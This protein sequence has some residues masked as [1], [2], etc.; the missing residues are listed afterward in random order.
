MFTKRAFRFLLTG[1]IA[2]TVGTAVAVTGVAGATASTHTLPRLNPPGMH[3]Q[4]VAA[5]P[6]P[7]STSSCGYHATIPADRFKGIP[8]FDA[9][10]A[11]QP[12]LVRFFTT[13]GVITVKM[14]TDKAPCT[15]YSFRFLASRGYFNQTHCHRLTVQFIYVLQCGDPTGTGSGAPGYSFNDENLAGATYPAGTVAMANAGPNTNGSQFFFTWKDTTLSPAYT[16]FGT[17]VGGMDVLQKIAAAGDDQ[18]NGP[19]DG[20]P[21]LYTAFLFVQ[22][23]PQ[24]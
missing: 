3:A 1:A 16:P 17:V 9:A 7:T 21:N 6:T 10:Q 14:L 8:V 19:G 4:T 15:T 5:D 11:A 2:V 12:F 18:Q 22:V 13:Q 20:Y 23:I 24:F